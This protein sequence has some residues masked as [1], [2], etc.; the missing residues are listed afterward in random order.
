MDTMG[1]VVAQR[2]PMLFVYTG[3]MQEESS[4]MDG[5]VQILNSKAQ[6]QVTDDM[7]IVDCF[8]KPILMHTYYE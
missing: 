1:M 7:T 2:P 5:K 8:G 6:V 3:I 4:R